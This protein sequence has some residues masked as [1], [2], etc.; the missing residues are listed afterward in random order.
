MAKKIQLTKPGT[1]GVSKVTRSIPVED[2]KGNKSIL[3][4]TVI[5][6]SP[7][8]VAKN[9]SNAI[10]DTIET[11]GIS[12][13]I[14]RPPLT[15]AELALLQEYSSE[16][17]QIIDSMTIGIEGFGG[18]LIQRKCE[19][20]HAEKNQAAI[21]EEKNWLTS[22]FELPNANGS[23]VTLRKET[24]EDLESTGNA[25]WE[26]VP[27][28]VK[29][30]RYSAVNK[31]DAPTMWITKSDKKFTPMRMNYVGPDMN[32]QAKTFMVRFRRYVQIVG[33]KRVWFK[34]FG[35]PRPIL[36]TTG[37]VAPEG[38]N[39]KLLANE[40]FHHK[41][42]TPRRTPYGMPRFTGN[43][44]A[45]KGSRS[46]DETNILTQQ[47]NH[48]PSMAI[49]VSGG[50]LTDGSVQRIREF[51]DTQIKASSNYSKF[52]ILEGESQHD[53]LSSSS[54]MKIEIKP[55]ADAQHKD[56]L[57]QEYDNNNA[58]KLRRSFR[59]PPILVGSS[60]NYD[61]AT[62]SVSE[63]LA[64]KY[65]FN[66]EREFMDEV[67]NRILLQ[68]GFKY[69]KFKSNSPNVTD[70]EDLTKI[71]TGGEK[72]GAV[73][74]RIARMMLE[75]ILNRELPEFKD[76]DDEGYFDPDVPF[77]LTLAKQMVGVGLANQNGTFANQG[78]N[79]TPDAGPSKN[80][81]DNVQPGADG[82][83]AQPSQS[84]QAAN[85]QTAETKTIALNGAQITS[86]VQIITDV[87]NQQLPYESAVQTIIL[88]F[89]LTR[90][91]AE[92]ILNPTK[93]FTPA[94]QDN[95]GFPPRAPAQASAPTGKNKRQQPGTVDELFDKLDPS[96]MINKLFENPEKTIARLNSIRQK[97][98][99][100]LDKEAFGKP[101]KDYFRHAT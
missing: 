12:D 59:L 60:E 32:V 89:G 30:D 57:W 97:L 93:G 68:Q 36:K 48:V 78:Q 43:I 90:D 21:V 73:T 63:A 66:P 42:Y 77:S 11:I 70:D 17:G 49:M 86:L 25:Y 35:D 47:N 101:R 9:Q 58:K 20:D 34:Q 56:Q 72:T 61:R 18:R 51:V 31:L 16:L 98:E 55:L 69:W 91:Q 3:K 37:E 65:V 46:A 85:A 74:P 92:S 23:F 87:A 33:N 100:D 13:K 44:I 29:K 64:E 83:P 38:T 52:L 24:R 8:A 1:S 7:N 28:P 53:G 10:E 5:T 99:D 76:K 14:I 94:P 71:I 50:M 27:S 95:P 22:F 26:L 81:A 2:T 82:Q 54:S 96:Q 80:P 45:I 41:I 67:I 6:V 75:D 39:K 15:Q 19:K 40:V 4:A 84:D 79:P 88:G 62:A